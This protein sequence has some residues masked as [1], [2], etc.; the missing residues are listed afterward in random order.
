MSWDLVIVPD[1]VGASHDFVYDEHPV[2]IALPS[3]DKIPTEPLKGDLLVFNGYREEEGKKTPLEFWVYAVD[4]TVLIQKEISVPAEIVSRHPNAYEIVP[5]AKQRELNQLTE[6]YESVAE[7]AF[8]LWV[9][10]LRWKCDNSAIG[11][12]KIRG[13]ESGWSTYLISRS[14][15]QG[16]WISPSVITVP[17]SK[18]VTTDIWK[19]AELALQNGITPPVFIE[20]MHDGIEH[21][22]AG[23][24]KRA[25]VDMA[26]ACES[27]LRA[28]VANSLP[29]GLAGSIS[30]YVDDANIRPVLTKFVPEI[31]ND[32][33]RGRLKKI[34]KRLHKLFDAR[35]DIVHI[36]KAAEINSEEVGK[37]LEATRTL[38]R[39]RM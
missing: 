7:K 1:L 23:D 22:K 11:R 35:N 9:R 8:D 38:L 27:F 2:R 20:L 6:V 21:M 24:L 28:L 29:N 15:G 19:E 32:E 4:V 3:K 34:E 10:T 13:H 25:T 37:H 17:A 5:E 31:L 18:A 33:E 12:P 26:V 16:I 14:T 30:E 39:L 36:G